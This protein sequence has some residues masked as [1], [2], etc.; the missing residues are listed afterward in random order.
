MRERGDRDGEIARLPRDAARSTPTT[1]PTLLA[2]AEAQMDANDLEGAIAT[3]EE[4][5]R[6]YPD[7]MRSVV[8][9]GFL[10]YEAR[11]FAGAAQRFER[12]LAADPRG[13][14]GRLLPGGRAAPDGR[15]DAAIE[16]FRASRPTT[17]T[18]P[19]RA[20]RSPRST[21]G[22]AT[23][24]ARWRRSSGRRP[25]RLRAPSISTRRRCAR[26]PAT[27]TAPSRTSRACSRRARRRRAALQHRR[28]LR[29]GEARR[30]RRSA[31]C[32]SRSSATPT[33][34]ARSTSSAT[35]GRSRARTSTRPS[36]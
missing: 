29:R 30:T 25:P 14:R 23:T 5:E 36:A 35:P 1:T 3:L 34:P 7:D 20:P 9:L 33:T 32:S 26:R 11:D 24:R 31:T 10:E 2:L 6:R 18:T 12:A 4:V 28:A 13:V 17:S 8:R 15:S 16:A 27:S 22:A 19:R 21:S